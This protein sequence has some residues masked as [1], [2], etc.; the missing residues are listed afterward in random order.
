M[1]PTNKVIVRRLY[2]EVWNKHKPELIP[3]IIAPSHALHDP[4]AAGSSIGP[5]AYQ[6][7]YSALVN[8]F[9]DLRFSIEDVISEGDKVVVSWTISGTHK[10][11]FMGVAPTGKKVSVD[12]VTINHLG[13]GKIMDSYVNWDALGLLRQIGATIDT[14]PM[15]SASAR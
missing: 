7:Q 11:E 5:E 13:N 1:A 12:G 9:P 4:N 15:K 2:E 6:R 10:G 8:A 3:E 14:S